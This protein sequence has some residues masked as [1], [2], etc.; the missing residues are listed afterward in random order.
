MSERPDGRSIA[1]DAV[2]A[3]KR[4]RLTETLRLHHPRKLFLALESGIPEEI[5]WALGG[6]LLASCPAD[7]ASGLPAIERLDRPTL[8]DVASL[9]RNPHL[10]RALFPVVAVVPGPPSASP[11]FPGV[12]SSAQTCALGVAHWRQAWLV[13]RNMSLMPENESSLAQSAALRLVLVR[14]LRSAFR[15]YEHEPPLTL[16]EVLAAAGEGATGDGAAKAVMMADTSPNE[17]VQG[18]CTISPYC[19]RGFRHC[20]RGGPCKI[21]QPSLRDSGRRVPPADGNEALPPPKFEVTPALSPPALSLRYDPLAHV[22]AAET[23]GNMCRQIRLEEL[24]GGSSGS[25][26]L[27]DVLSSLACCAEAPLSGMAIEA[28]G[29]RAPMRAWHRPSFRLPKGPLRAYRTLTIALA[30]PLSRVVAGRLSSIDSNEPTLCQMALASP[31]LVS[32][33]CAAINELP[34]AASATDDSAAL[35]PPPSALQ[36]AAVEALVTLSNGSSLTLRLG[37]ANERMLIPRLLRLLGAPGSAPAHV[38][39]RAAQVLVN[40]ADAPECHDALRQHA[41][42]MMHMALHD[43]ML[44]SPLISEVLD[45]LGE[46]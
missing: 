8:A 5:S 41:W 11:L 36:E 44:A 34:A 25:A 28:I 33:I 31:A 30:L 15:E 3:A 6:L 42:M 1:R 12:P 32:A 14:T 20:G 38:S 19:V 29:A 2:Q 22:A 4:A 10:L 18:Q 13:L 24:G 26:E 45:L 39:R 7:A 46:K 17:S 27:C 40:L 37:L 16:A 9:V 43:P 35:A 23:L 21:I